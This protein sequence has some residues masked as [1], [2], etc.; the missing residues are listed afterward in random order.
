MRHAAS[1]TC[2]LDGGVVPGMLAQCRQRRRCARS[3]AALQ[4][5]T[6]HAAQGGRRRRQAWQAAQGAGRSSAGCR[7]D[8]TRVAAVHAWHAGGRGKAAQGGGVCAEKKKGPRAG[9]TE[10][11]AQ[12]K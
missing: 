5:A 1:G 7:G 9:G 12:R 8:L 6:Q 11:W 10:I 4:G 2:D 3:E